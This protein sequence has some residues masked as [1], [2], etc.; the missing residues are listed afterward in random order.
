MCKLA[1]WVEVC[2]LLAPRTAMRAGIR[3]GLAV[4]TMVPKMLQNPQRGVLSWIRVF[5]GYGPGGAAGGRGCR[6]PHAG[7]RTPRT[8]YPVFGARGP[9]DMRR[10]PAR[11]AGLPPGSENVPVTKGARNTAKVIC[12][13]VQVSGAKNAYPIP[14]R[15]RSAGGPSGIF[16]R[17]IAR[18]G[19]R[20]ASPWCDHT[21]ACV[22]PPSCCDHTPACV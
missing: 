13:T 20:I 19:P 18:P 2:R 9:A 16:R 22:S 10:R 15:K 11:K 1:F 12:P 17:R 14:G 6:L 3:R 4:R 8:R 7:G 5:S 21:P